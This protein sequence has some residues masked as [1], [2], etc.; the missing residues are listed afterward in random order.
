M[1]DYGARIRTPS[2]SLVI[3]GQYQNLALRAKGSSTTSGSLFWVGPNS[4]VYYGVRTLQFS[5]GS[6]PCIAIRSI[7]PCFIYNQTY[8]NGVWTFTIFILSDS[9]GSGL[10]EWYLF[11]SPDYAGLYN[12][13]YG[14]IVRNQYTGVK[15]FDSRCPYMRVLGIIAANRP[16]GMAEGQI[17]VNQ[18]YPAGKIAVIQS[19]QAYEQFN[20]TVSPPP[21][22]QI[23][24]L[25]FQSAFSVSEATLLAKNVLLQDIQ[26][27]SAIG[28]GWQYMYHLT[29][30][31]V[32]NF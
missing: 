21:N 31:D 6:T 18:T 23:R 13:A 8:S 2:G 19:Q 22:Q 5:G 29:I 7:W 26:D 27:T 9:Q 11:D 1:A 30:I 4:T 10:I 16:Q 24:N 28:G 17:F 12:T 32:S 14:V 15:V 20:I 25:N 3:D